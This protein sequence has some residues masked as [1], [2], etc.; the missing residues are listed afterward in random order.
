MHPLL[1]EVFI[2]LKG[3]V[4]KAN[5]KGKVNDWGVELSDYIQF[6]FIKGV[7]NTVADTPITTN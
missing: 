1:L 6:K 4:Q 2:Y 7:K 3:V 5:S